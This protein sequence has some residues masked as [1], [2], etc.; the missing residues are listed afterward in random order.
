MALCILHFALDWTYIGDRV[1]DQLCQ[2]GHLKI[3]PD[4][5]DGSSYIGWDHVENVCRQ[6]GET[7]DAQIG[8]DQKDGNSDRIEQVGQIIVRLPQFEVAIAELIIERIQF[9]VCRLQLFL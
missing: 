7:P 4:V 5:R 2:I 3:V 9:F 6:R 1:P 8:A